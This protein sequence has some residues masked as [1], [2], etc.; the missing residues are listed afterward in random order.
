MPVKVIAKENLYRWTNWRITETT[1]E[2]EKVDARTIH[3]PVTIKPDGEVVIRYTV[4]Y[5]W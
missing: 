2:Y 4:K 3:F 5:T 1:H